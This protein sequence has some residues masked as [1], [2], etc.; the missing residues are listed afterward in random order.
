MQEELLSRHI[1]IND[2]DSFERW[3]KAK[4]ISFVDSNAFQNPYVKKN[5]FVVDTKAIKLSQ[6]SKK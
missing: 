5:N 6:M 2:A 3:E 4:Q 1:L